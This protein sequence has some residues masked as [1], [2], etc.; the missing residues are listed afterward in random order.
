L[1]LALKSFAFAVPENNLFSETFL[2]KQD[3]LTFYG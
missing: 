1:F 2:I 3:F